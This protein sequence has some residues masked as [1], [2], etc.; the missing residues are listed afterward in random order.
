MWV[1]AARGLQ[2]QAVVQYDAKNRIARTCTY[3][4]AVDVCT[5]YLCLTCMIVLIFPFAVTGTLGILLYI[6]ALR[7]ICVCHSM[8]VAVAQKW[9]VVPYSCVEVKFVVTTFT[10][11]RRSRA[12][13]PL[14]D[15]L[16]LHI[17]CLA[18]E[19]SGAPKS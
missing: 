14:N 17:A 8:L 19:Y 18:R 7:L 4:G 15:K 11:V 9:R 1:A 13:Q 12:A 6:H 2:Q 5:L 16:K 3:K 10:A